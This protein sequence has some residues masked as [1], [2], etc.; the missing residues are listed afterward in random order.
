[1]TW[2]FS[3]V[4]R[5]KAYVRRRKGDAVNK[6]S[7][8]IKRGLPVLDFISTVWSFTPQAIPEGPYELSHELVNLYLQASERQSY[9]HIAEILKDLLAQL[10]ACP[11][12]DMDGGD[13]DLGSPRRLPTFIVNTRV[14]LDGSMVREGGTTPDLM[15]SHNRGTTQWRDNWESCL[16]FVEIKHSP[17]AD[18]FLSQDIKIDL[19]AFSK[20]PA[21][22]QRLR[23]HTPSEYTECDSDSEMVDGEASDDEEDNE[24]KRSPSTASDFDEPAAKRPCRRSSISSLTLVDVP[25]DQN[26]PLDEYEFHAALYIAEMME[27]SI[28]SY[29]SGFSVEDTTVTL[30]YGDRMGL[31][32]SAEFDFLEE[33]HLL[34]LTAAALDAANIER[35]GVLPFLRTPGHGSDDA[36]LVFPKGRA[37]DALGEPIGEEFRFRLCDD[38]AP[39]CK[40]SDTMVGAGTMIFYLETIPERRDLDGEEFVAK[41]SWPLERS[42]TET[43]FLRAVTTGLRNKAPRYTPR[44]FMLMV[45]KRYEPLWDVEH[46]SEFRS[47]FVDVVRAHHWVAETS[48]ILH[49][50]IS[51]GNI[52]FYRQYNGKVIGVLM[53][54]DHSLRRNREEEAMFDLEVPSSDDPCTMWV[55]QFGTTQWWYTVPYL[56]VARSCAQC[57][58]STWIPPHRYEHDLEAFFWVLIHFLQQFEPGDHKVYPTDF[59][60]M[61][62]SHD[63]LEWKQSFLAAEKSEEVYQEA[64][65]RVEWHYS[66]LWKEWVPRLRDLVAHAHSLRTPCT[67][68][69]RDLRKSLPE[70]SRVGYQEEIDEI[71]GQLREKIEQRKTAFTYKKFMAALGEPLDIPE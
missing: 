67:V 44:R 5:E 25:S 42:V 8:E 19:S 71:V 51:L 54:W 33:P 36:T 38:E 68:S 2:G 10:P 17:T 62:D 39:S 16:A 14:I 50:D 41:V 12:D 15:W 32:T 70:A 45:M 46:V 37:C 57:D 52:M 47:V 6:C 35:F 65:E 34:L 3:S 43:A 58:G 13:S 28:R 23:S 53:D 1:M 64:E 18:F 11:D 27:R 4:A 49:G 7:T 60:N 22:K 69:E 31:V 29:A 9:M 30:W 26:R 66:P 61:R 24:L 63:V 55:Y 20:R 21:G 56:D 59:F 48:D 40:T